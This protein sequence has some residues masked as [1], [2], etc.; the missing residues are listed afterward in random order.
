MSRGPDRLRPDWKRGDV[1]GGGFLPDCVLEGSS[2]QDSEDREGSRAPDRVRHDAW[3]FCHCHADR[4]TSSEHQHSMRKTAKKEEEE[5]KR[6]NT[7]TL[8]KQA[9]NSASG[10]TKSV[11]S[12]PTIAFEYEREATAAPKKTNQPWKLEQIIV[13]CRESA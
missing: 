2:E 6:E 9:K 3:G 1:L 7:C 13:Y 5:G 12:E 4:C 11:V 10:A 8:I